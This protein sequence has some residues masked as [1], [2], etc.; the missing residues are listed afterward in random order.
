MLSKCASYEIGLQ[1]SSRDFMFLFFFTQ[2]KKTSGG[3]SDLTTSDK[4]L[5]L[6]V[7]ESK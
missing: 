6:S 4:T 3:K 2:R 1:H 7:E 5:T